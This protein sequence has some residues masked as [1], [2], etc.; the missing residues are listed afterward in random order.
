MTLFYLSV[1]DGAHVTPFLV[2][3]CLS[4]HQ[5][6]V[7]NMIKYIVLVRPFNKDITVCL[8]ILAQ[9]LFWWRTIIFY[10]LSY[11]SI[12]NVK[13]KKGIHNIALLQNSYGIG[14][15]WHSPHDISFWCTHIISVIWGIY[16]FIHQSLVLSYLF[17]DSVPKLN[18]AT[19]VSFFLFFVFLLWNGF[20]TFIGRLISK[21][22]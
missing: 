16:G 5:Q 21:T 4:Y 22:N 8:W 17:Y 18:D 3:I 1:S 12:Y 7:F 14:S 20:T 9:I 2:C 19:I 15:N 13:I 11:L 6:G 10:R